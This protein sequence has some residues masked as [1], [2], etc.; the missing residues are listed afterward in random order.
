MNIK[1]LNYAY[2]AITTFCFEKRNKTYIKYVDMSIAKEK[3]GRG[4]KFIQCFWQ[5]QKAGINGA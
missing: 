2:E 3:V 4:R 5:V 1:S